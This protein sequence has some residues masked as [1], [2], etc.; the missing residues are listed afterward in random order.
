MILNTFS[1]A[2]WPSV[3]PLWRNVY[4]G[5]PPI[6]DWIVTHTHTHTHTYGCIS[7]LYILEI[8]P[9]WLAL[10]ASILPFCGLSLCL[11]FPLLYKCFSVQLGSICL[12]LFLFSL[13]WEIDQ[14]RSYYD[15]C[16]RIFSR[17]FLLRVL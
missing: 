1:R 5:L 12:F 11:W 17:C 6:F 7:C 15:L 16:H 3:C 9:L 13:L 14:K 10:F 4:L 2:S 8:N